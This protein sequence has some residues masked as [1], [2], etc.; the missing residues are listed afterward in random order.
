MYAHAVTSPD[1]LATVPGIPAASSLRP[2]R[3]AR[4]TARLR[5]ARLDDALAAGEDPASSP[6]LAARAAA[7]TATP[8]RRAL[9]EG[10]ERVL[11][12]AQ[13]PP[14]LH[15]LAPARGVIR[16]NAA[17]LS[18]LAALLREDAPLY[19]PGLA[20]LARILTDGAGPL[21]ARSADGDAL[22]AALGD[23]RSALSG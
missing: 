8:T 5:H 12:R 7:L 20:M 16:A 18:E 6:A 19:A 13:A 21:Y 3:W 15:A 9:A 23:A 11:D 1:T 10:L 2:S 17:A 14:R 4:L 22:A